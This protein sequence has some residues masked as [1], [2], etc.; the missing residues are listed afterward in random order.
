MAKLTS[1]SISITFLEKAASLIERGS[2]GIVALVLRDASVTGTGTPDTYTVRDVS[3]V[4]TTLSEANQQYIKDALKGYSKAPLKVLVYVMPTTTGD[5]SDL[6]S[7]MLKYFETETFQWM[8]IPTV[9]TDGKVEDIISWVKSQRGNNNYMIKAVLPNADSADCEGII[10]WTSKLYRD[11][12]SDNGDNSVTITRKTYTAEQG[13]PR[14]AGIFAGMDVTISA[15]YAPLKDFDDVE[16]LDSEARN[17]AVGNGKLLGFWD[18]EKVK[19]DRAVTSFVTTTGVKGDS[20][21]KAKLVEDMDM[22]KSDIQ[23]TIQ[24]SYIGKYANSY[25]NKCLL[26]TA[27]NGYFQTLVNAGIIESGTVEI[28]LTSQRTYLE[29]LGKNVTVNGE[30]KKPADLSDDEVKIANT[31]SHVFLRATVV[32]L[33]A[34]EDVSLTINV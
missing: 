15:T 23:T 28:D 33:D 13:T 16:R 25:D 20:F 9:E 18:R 7:A 1:P 10:N 12:T 14:I 27:I 26:I 11:E 2:R 31:G 17:T 21:K 6:Y 30:T 19:L 34:I 29:S 5:V 24:D 8:A 4:P 22:I 3:D 32:L